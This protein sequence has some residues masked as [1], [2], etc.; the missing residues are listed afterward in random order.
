M[1]HSFP[2]QRRGKHSI[3]EI[4]TLPG[5]IC[6]RSKKGNIRSES[7]TPG[8]RK[9][10]DPLLRNTNCSVIHRKSQLNRF[11]PMNHGNSVDT[12]K[13]T[14]ASVPSGTA[15]MVP[16]FP[17]AGSRNRSERSRGFRRKRAYPGPKEGRGQVTRRA[18]PSRSTISFFFCFR[19]RYRQPG[20]ITRPRRLWQD[21]LLHMARY[22]R[23]CAGRA[24]G[25]ALAADSPL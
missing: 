4:G 13:E 9:R 2:M 25:R 17:R 23:R 19:S 7:G 15:G 21:W 5:V 24:S 10:R 20:R 6:L 14:F 22:V 18:I 3:F 8:N 1:N 11:G 16:A 12:E